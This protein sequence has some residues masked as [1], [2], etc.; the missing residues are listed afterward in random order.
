MG[1]YLINAETQKL[2]MHFSREEYMELAED[3][4]R[5]IKSACLFSRRSGAWVSRGKYPNTYTAEKIAKEIGLEYTGIEGEADFAAQAARNAARAQE[6][7]DRYEARAAA[8]TREGEVLTAPIERVRGDIAFMTQPNI[9][10][11][12]GRAFTRQ[13]ERMFAAYDRGMEAFRQ[14]EWYEQKAEWLRQKASSTPDKGFCERRIKEASHDIKALRNNLAYYEGI[15]KRVETG[16]MVRWG[17]GET[18]TPEH[19]ED[20]IA[21][22][23]MQL[24][25][26]MS[27]EA[28]YTELLEALG[29]LTYSRENV[30]AGDM[31]KV[32]SYGWYEVVRAN[33]KT[34]TVNTGHGF[35]LKFTC[36]E[37][38][39]VKGKEV[40][41]E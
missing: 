15:A 33:P 38:L 26:E 34:V 23:E 30:H 28:Y 17:N 22:A 2:E 35:Q 19:I 20:T 40:K 1:T 12:A 39:E 25:Q 27:K 14:S 4:K 10:S 36:G 16:E 8:K 41:E 6:R 5:R 9:N 32:S 24:A 21:R 31:V 29:G 3:M 7:A 18:V 11:S 37:I 13:R